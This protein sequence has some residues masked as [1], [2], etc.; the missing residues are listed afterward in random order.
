MIAGDHGVGFGQVLARS[1]S[2][3]T[4]I[5]RAGFDPA[6]VWVDTTLARKTTIDMTTA[7]VSFSLL[8][9]AAAAVM[10]LVAGTAFAAAQQ[11]VALVNGEPIT[12]L[13]IAQRTKMIQLSTHKSP[14]R[15]VVLDELIDEALKLQ[16]ARKY[17]LE[18][19]EAEINGVFSNMASRMRLNA[20]QF[21]TVLGNSGI[22]AKGLKRKIKA[23]MVW[24]QII[25][26]KFQSSFQF[27]EK[28][29]ESAFQQ[30]NTDQKDIGAYEYTLRPILFIVERGSP[31]SVLINRRRE[32]EQLRAR[33]QGCEQGLAMARSLK[34]VAVRDQI[35]KTTADLTPQLRTL[36]NGMEVGK[37]TAP[38]V[39]PQGIE[40]FALCGKHQTLGDSGER[41]DA[42]DEMFSKQFQ[43]QA[44]RYLEELRRGS[45]IE[46]R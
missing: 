18:I 6:G 36:L 33:F 22:S 41:K 13:D 9:R 15:K 14:E 19:T 1:G 34:D 32:A 8:R 45:I 12:Q 25:R 30:K 7:T 2:G 38:D 24:N 23:D 4:A 11:V 16:T 40:V 26:G 43:A 17:R 29:V 3:S 27:R 28:D 39:T 20:Q 5:R 37:L 35:V 31:D 44:K 42:R 10:L 21:T 46:M